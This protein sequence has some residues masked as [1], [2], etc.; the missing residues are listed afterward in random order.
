MF[1]DNFIDLCETAGESPSR[2][3]TALGISKGSLSR[4]KD[5]GEPLNETKKKIAD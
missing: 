2:V 4:W 3:L 1:Y 5:G